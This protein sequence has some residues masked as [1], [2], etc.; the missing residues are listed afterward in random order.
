MKSYS[1]L[2]VL[3]T[4]MVGII[5]SATANAE[6]IPSQTILPEDMTVYLHPEYGVFRKEVK[7]ATLKSL[8]TNNDYRQNP[9][10]YLNCI[11]KN[12]EYS[13]Y[14]TG[15]NEHVKGQMRVKGQYADGYCIPHGHEEKGVRNDPSFKELCERNFPKQCVN[16]SCELQSETAHWF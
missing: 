5:F 15:P 14:S 7:P 10:C 2:F 12:P 8:P 11:S 4:W 3:G 13:V 16:G 1:T 9:G 6:T